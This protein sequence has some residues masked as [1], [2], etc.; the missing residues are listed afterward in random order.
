MD[1]SIESME[2]KFRVVWTDPKTG[3]QYEKE[4]VRYG[5]AEHCKI[6]AERTYPGAKV[7]ITDMA[8]I[9]VEV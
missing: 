3:M 8:G 4:Y 1:A 9:N 5:T 7:K 2:P 6:H